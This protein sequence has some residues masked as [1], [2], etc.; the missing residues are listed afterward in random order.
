MFL[1]LRQEKLSITQ[2]MEMLFE[3][4]TLIK[5]CIFKVNTFLVGRQRKRD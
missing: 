2:R 3:K 1:G 5:V 4:V